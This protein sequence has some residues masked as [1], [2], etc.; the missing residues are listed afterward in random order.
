MINFY[1][2]IIIVDLCEI[3]SWK[4]LNFTQRHFKLH[5]YCV[6]KT[7]SPQHT[8]K[9]KTIF[10]YPLRLSQL[11][12]RVFFPNPLTTVAYWLIKIGHFKV[13]R[14]SLDTSQAVV[15]SC[16]HWLVESACGLKT[17]E[18]RVKKIW[19]NLLKKTCCLANISLM[20]LSSGAIGEFKLLIFC[21]QITWPH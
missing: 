20:I 1:S 13:C 5:S 8:A 15:A 12:L 4:G 11:S 9:K 14:P 19:S 17:L 6:V 7:I 16:Y 18:S 2:H 10:V 21:F 3:I